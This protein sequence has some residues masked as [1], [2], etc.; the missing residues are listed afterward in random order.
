MLVNIPR[1]VTAYYA[2][3]PDPTLRAQRVPFGTSG[4]RGSSLRNSFNEAQIL[5]VTHAICAMEKRLTIAGPS[6]KFKSAARV[7]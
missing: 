3:R 5:A 2:E 1:L 7:L 6:L 4:H